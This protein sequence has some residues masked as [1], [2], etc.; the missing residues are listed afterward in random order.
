MQTWLAEIGRTETRQGQL[1]Y[2]MF[3]FPFLMFDVL[4]PLLE[5]SYKMA[6]CWIKYQIYS[7]IKYLYL[8]LPSWA[9]GGF[10]INIIL[11]SLEAEFL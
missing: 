10:A 1:R 6:D 5:V 11:L 7:Q 4:L 2:L 8:T 9:A 3:L